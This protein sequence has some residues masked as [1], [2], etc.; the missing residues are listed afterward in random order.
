MRRKKRISYKFTEKTHS[1]RG[2]RAFGMALIS[3]IVGISVVVISFK[4]AGNASVYVGS[5]GLFSLVLSFVALIIGIK[6]LKEEESYKIFPGLGTAF[7]AIAFLG[8]LAIYLA[9]FYI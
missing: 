2:I 5:A 7:S 9:G 3:I 4:S 1:K 8:W 6:S